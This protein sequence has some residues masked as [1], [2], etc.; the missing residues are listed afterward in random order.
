MK[1]VNE[2]RRFSQWMN[3]LSNWFENR[4]HALELY[5]FFTTLAALG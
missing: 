1:T 4:R 5:L 2:Q 3:V